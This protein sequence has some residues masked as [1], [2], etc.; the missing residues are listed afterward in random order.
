MQQ[1][2]GHS[3]TSGRQTSPA[4]TGLAAALGVKCRLAIELGCGA[5]KRVELEKRK[6]LTVNAKMG[7]TLTPGRFGKGAAAVPNRR[8]QRKL[9]QSQGLV[10]FAVKLD[11]DLVKRLHA[12]AQERGAGINEVVAELLKKGLSG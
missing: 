10:P 2:A 12:A 11:G 7:Q 4:T 3:A 5:V 1:E 8:E 6:G 9:D